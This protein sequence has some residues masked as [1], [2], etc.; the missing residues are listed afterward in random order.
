MVLIAYFQFLSLYNFQANLMLLT[1][2]TKKLTQP[3]ISPIYWTL[4]V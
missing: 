2:Y 4:K 1:N 3:L